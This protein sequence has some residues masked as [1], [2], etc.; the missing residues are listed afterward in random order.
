MLRYS[1]RTELTGTP[2]DPNTPKPTRWVVVESPP[3]I[4]GSELQDR[5][6]CAVVAVAV[7]DYQIA[8]SLKPTGATKFGSWTGANTNEYMGVVLND[9]VKSI[10]FIKSQITDS[11]EIEGKFTKAVCR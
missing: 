6:G 4:N 8:F 1:E 5:V 10:A 11:G 3:I 7:N 9:E 2:Q